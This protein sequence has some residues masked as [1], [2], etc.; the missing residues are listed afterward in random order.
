ML[1]TVVKSSVRVLTCVVVVVLLTGIGCVN[2]LMF[3]PEMSRGGY[4][5]STEGYVDI[6]TNGVK[7]AALVLGPER[8]KK[9]ILR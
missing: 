7:I 2:S 3:H 1:K 9:A 8:G 6:G 5:E 4:G